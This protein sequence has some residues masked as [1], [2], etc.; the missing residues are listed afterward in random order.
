MPAK[1]PTAAKVNIANNKQLRS[2]QRFICQETGSVLYRQQIGTY[3]PL[4]SEK[5][6]MTTDEMSRIKKF[7]KVGMTLMGFKPKTY[8]K[9]Y[10][11]VKHSTFVY[12]DESRVQGSS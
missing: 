2:T 12:P 8:L 10:H 3:Y 11:N 9:V 4:G 7:D 1:K 6:K 5:V